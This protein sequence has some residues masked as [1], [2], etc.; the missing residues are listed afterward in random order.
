MV[1]ISA[2]LHLEGT[3]FLRTLLIR[4]EMNNDATSALKPYITIIVLVIMIPGILFSCA[5]S[6]PSSDPAEIV[7]PAVSYFSIDRDGKSVPISQ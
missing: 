1:I 3:V 4:I 2:V 5:S 6:P 7:E